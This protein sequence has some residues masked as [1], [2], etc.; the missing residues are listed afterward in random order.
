MN[1]R[2]LVIGNK[3]YSSWSLRPWLFL[4][5]NNIDFVEKQLWLDEDPFRTEIAHYD[6]GGKVPV[7]IDSGVEV[8]DS[9]A[10]IEY[11]VDR[12]GCEACGPA[13]IKWRAHARSISCEMHSSFMALRAECP[14]DIRGRHKIELS[15]AAQSD[16]DR[17]CH[18]WTQALEISGKQGRWLYGDFS[19]ADAMFV[20]V[21]FR[22]VGFGVE[23]NPLIQA[24]VDFVLADKDVK[25]R[26]SDAHQETQF[27]KI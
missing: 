13:E 8:W 16:I 20:P 14:M 4:R 25:Q 27:L 9:L 2:T 26:I 6:S 10:I 5:K 18:I 23:L 1:S 7:L 11:A 24:Y 17:I 21:I 19:V 3:N 22:F 15:P 12:Y